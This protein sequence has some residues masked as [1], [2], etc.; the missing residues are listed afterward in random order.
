ME[1]KPAILRDAVVHT[2]TDACYVTQ[3][4]SDSCTIVTCH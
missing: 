3:Y 1:V 2:V 4:D